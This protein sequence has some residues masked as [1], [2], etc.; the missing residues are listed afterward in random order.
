MTNKSAPEDTF[1]VSPDDEEYL[2][3]LR[4]EEEFWDSRTETLLTETPRRSVQRYLNER[5]TG[6]PDKLWYETIGDEGEFTNG[7]VFG[8][9]P[10]KVEEYLL[11][12]QPRLHLTIFD[13]SGDALDRL[14]QRLDRQY[15]ER[16]QT[17]KQDL[18]FRRPSARIL[19]TGRRELV[20]SPQPRPRAR[21]ISAQ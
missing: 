5:Y 16:I 19:R 7:C 8:A 14:Q 9:G 12:R 21:S 1:H 13:I 10:G 17:R 2:K 15:H 11:G 18:N 3:M 4:E 20:H 6:D